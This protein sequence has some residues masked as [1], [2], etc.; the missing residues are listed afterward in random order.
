MNVEN[1]REY[2]YS[3]W[4][5]TEKTDTFE[6]FKN[7]VIQ[8]VKN[9]I[10]NTENNVLKGKI[11]KLEIK[12]LCSIIKEENGIDKVLRVC[13]SLSKI[14]KIL[15]EATIASDINVVIKEI[16]KSCL[17]K[18]PKQTFLN[19]SKFNLQDQN[20]IFE[21][22]KIAAEKYPS[23]TMYIFKNFGLKNQEYIFEIAKICLELEKDPLPEFLS[24]FGFTNQKYIFEIVEYFA[25]TNPQGTIDNFK[26]FGL[27][28]PDYIFKIL[29][30]CLKN[31]EISIQK[32][33]E[34]I[35][36]CGLD[37]KEYQNKIIEYSE[38][39]SLEKI[40]WQAKDNPVEI[41]DNFQKLELK[42]QKSIYEIVKICAKQQPGYVASKFKTLGLKD[43]EYIYEIAKI[44]AEKGDESFNHYFEN[45]GLKN[46]EKIYEIYK[47]YVVNLS[48]VGLINKAIHSLQKYKIS[49]AHDMYIDFIKAHFGKSFAETNYKYL[50]EKIQRI[51]DKKG[52]ADLRA[53]EAVLKWV[54]LVSCEIRNKRFSLEE[55]QWLIEQDILSTFIDIRS[56]QLR[57][58]LLPIIIFA[59]K[60]ISLKFKEIELFNSYLTKG[61]EREV[62][63]KARSNAILLKLLLV[64]LFVWGKH[65]QTNNIKVLADRLDTKF[66]LK[67]QAKVLEVA[68]ALLLLSSCHLDIEN[69]I[70]EK[71]SSENLN[72]KILYKEFV[73]LKSLLLIR[74]LNRSFEKENEFINPEKSFVLSLRETI[75]K[76]IPSLN[77]IVDFDKKME[78]T[79]LASRMPEA[80]FCYVSTLS[81]LKEPK[82][83]ACLANF[84]K[85]VLEGTFIEERNS[86]D[87]N[88]H[89][90]KIFSHNE[91]LEKKW[92]TSL[93]EKIGETLTITDSEDPF[94]LL[95]CGTEVQGSCLGAKG[96]A[97]SNKGLLA[98]LVDGK[99]RLIV[100]KDDSGRMIA[101]A[102]LRI[103]ICDDKPVLFLERSYPPE[104]LEF[105]QE[106]IE[107]L[108]KEKAKLLGIPLFKTALEKGNVV[109][110][111]IGSPAPYEYTDAG[112]GGISVKPNGEYEIIKASEIG[113]N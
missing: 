19:F 78:Y 53:Q 20:S 106:A 70:I 58:D 36:K 6:D 12:N 99:N 60:N 29:Q 87:N 67:D 37:V 66:F 48:H 82:V 35:S 3:L 74:S 83:T 45:F 56:I 18:D 98:Y 54:C 17:E 23:D 107:E 75:K 5:A 81:T 89:L 4:A 113:Y 41:I 15:S 59:R 61:L 88:P 97:N 65:E 64:E 93:K 90:Q 44:C 14:N 77:E 24:N 111:S 27:V 85:S 38:L 52:K 76:I 109:L 57:D 104:L 25:H 91:E 34:I 51:K 30:I 26:T 86:K 68:H 8:I 94:N 73:A 32:M 22:V 96:D 71:L 108:A 55:K 10:T 50:F 2:Q 110:K 105:Q 92:R 11:S 7:D 28:N 95:L 1:Q 21:V 112:E 47:I 80:I 31:E 46:Q 9:N 49:N 69:K 62:S 42:D 72:N 103:L 101:R 43:Q 63:P 16:V 100:I 13:S 84:I 39:V 33:Q 102:V 79:F 40:K